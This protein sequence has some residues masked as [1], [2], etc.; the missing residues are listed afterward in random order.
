MSRIAAAFARL[1]DRADAVLPARARG[2]VAIG[3]AC[4]IAA[5]AGWLV[6]SG[7]MTGLSGFDRAAAEAFVAGDPYGKAGLFA[8]VAI[9]PWKWVIGAPTAGA[10]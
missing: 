1:R 3:A 4:A 8:G 10:A 7:R 6:H 5:T 2:P 9:K